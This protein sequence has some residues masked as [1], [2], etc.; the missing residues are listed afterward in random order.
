M[1]CTLRGQPG[2]RAPSALRLPQIL[3]V[4][5]MRS[6]P[7][8]I[9]AMTTSSRGFVSITNESHRLARPSLLETGRLADYISNNVG[10]RALRWYISHAD[11]PELVIQSTDV[12]YDISRG[13]PC[14][15]AL[16]SNKA[17][18]LSLIPTGV[19]CEIGG[20]AG[21][22]GPATRLLSCAV[23]FLTRSLGNT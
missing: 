18:A 16:L 1:V 13:S 3:N 6:Q 23:D 12:N 17:V 2:G 4:R 22:A 21:D 19:R 10:L 11:G 14:S 7:H 5:K 9:R 20:Y 15:E 8:I